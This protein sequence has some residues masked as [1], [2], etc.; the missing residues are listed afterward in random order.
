VASSNLIKESTKQLDVYRSESALSQHK[1]WAMKSLVSHRM[2][3]LHK[4]GAEIQFDMS[5]IVSGKGVNHE[6]GTGF[7][8][9]GHLP[10]FYAITTRH[11]SARARLVSN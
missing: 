7:E 9:T 5:N 4:R 3:V 10:H 1:S 6:I 8:Q 11:I 2:R